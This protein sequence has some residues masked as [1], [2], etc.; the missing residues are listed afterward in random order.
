MATDY[1]YCSIKLDTLFEISMATDYKYCPIN[2]G[3]IIW[4]IYGN[5]LPI[6]FHQYWI[7]YLKYLWL[8]ITNTVPSIP[9]TL[10]EIS[11][12][13]DC[14]Y[15][16]IKTGYIIWNIYGYRLQILSHQYW[17]H[18]LK[19]LWQQIT[20][21]VPSILVTLFETSMATDYK[22]CSFN[23]GY[24]I[25]NIYGYRLQ[26]LFHQYWLHD[27]KCLW[28]KVTN[29]VPSILD[30][31]FEISMATDHKYCS[32][33][34][35]YI[36]WNVYGYILQILF[37]QY[38]KHY[39][40]YLWLQ[41]TNTVPSILDTLFEIS[42]ATD[43][44]YCSINTGYIIWSIYGYRLQILFHQ[45]WKHYLKYLWLQIT[46]TVPSILDTLFEIIYGY[47][48]QILFHQYWK[49]YLK[50]QWL[51]ITNTVPSILDTLFEIIYGYILQILFH[52]Y[53]IHYLKHLWLQITNTVPSILDT[54]LLI[55]Y[56]SDHESSSLQ[57]SVM[58]W[59]ILT[60][61]RNLHYNINN[62]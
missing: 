22:Y 11:M 19:Y 39:L 8:Q 20:N 52:Q 23:T 47:R 5:R 40:K 60:T 12:A 55:S 38:W 59:Y 30:T 29:T 62:S 43:Y 18:Y 9:D 41:V 6:L 48:L 37:H 16:S 28:L 10:F 36:I 14:K 21:N 34:T 49:H 1:K 13:T 15:C 24:I 26:I 53:W 44:K 25:W 31:L 58:C 61:M 45:Y 51:Q 33:N 17:I 50:Y 27:S 35:G 42:M 3:Y 46:N 57:W 54:L 56:T 4:N 2:T 32:I 7:H